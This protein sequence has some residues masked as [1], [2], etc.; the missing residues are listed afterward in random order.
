MI[1]DIKKRTRTL[2]RYMWGYMGTLAAMGLLVGVLGMG[3]YHTVTGSAENQAVRCYSGLFNSSDA[4]EPTGID[5]LPATSLPAVP[6]L[7]FEYGKNGRLERLVHISAEGHPIAMPGSLVA[8]QRMEYDKADRLV[9]KSNY[10]AT[11]EPTVDAS[12]VHARVF[13]YDEKGRL[14][15][16]EFQDRSGQRIVPRMPGYAMECIQY[17]AQGRPLRIDYRDGKGEPITNTRGEQQIIFAY[18]DEHNT[19]T[20]TNFVAGA[21]A[22]NAQGIAREEECRT[23]DGR[24][25][26]IMWFNAAGER[27]HQ[28]AT[29][30]CSVLR[31]STREG[32]LQRE[33]YCDDSG[34]MCR[35]VRTCAERLV[36]TTPQ[37]LVEWECYNDA[38]GIPCVNDALGY[39]E[40]VCEYG[41]DGALL[42]EYFWDENGNPCTRYEK[43]YTKSPDGKH[44]LS[45]LADG[46]TELRRMW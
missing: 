44:V 12:G 24:S 6:H 27:A 16:T 29:G 19:S 9:R 32:T 25:T 8:E 39:A 38:D 1:P 41:Q 10:T 20:R 21:P 14:V 5:E 42:R 22:D 18:D 15:C 23:A 40:R 37:G 17:D 35:H 7:R 2:F 4:T 31:E 46:S 34:T 33:R 13:R 26:T 43:R 11:G 3:I 36:R 45:L 30:A 28:P